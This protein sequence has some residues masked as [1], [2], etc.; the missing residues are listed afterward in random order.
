MEREAKAALQ[1]EL[2]ALELDRSEQIRALSRHKELV[3]QKLAE[4]NS[5]NEAATKALEERLAQEQASRETEKARADDTRTALEGERSNHVATARNLALAQDALAAVQG[6]THAMIGR[7]GQLARGARSNN[8]LQKLLKIPP[9]GKYN[10]RLQRNVDQILGFLA[11]FTD[12]ELGMVSTG[13]EDRV[14]AYMLGMTSF[15]ADMPPLDRNVYLTLHPD[16]AKLKVDPFIHY[17]DFGQREGRS[18]HPLLDYDYYTRRYPET[19]RYE[20]SVLEHYLRFGAA[21][22]YDPCEMFSTSDYLARYP[23]VQHTKYN[24]LLHYLRHPDCQ[25]HPSFDSNFYRK[26]YPDVVRAG[27]NPLV[28]FLLWG[29]AEGRQPTPNRPAD[30][31]HEVQA[32]G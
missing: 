29:R 30:S 2:S 31:G 13:R 19:A 32:G 8:W 21:E 23:D 12:A 16:V 26:Q 11:Q 18:P 15:V 9:I 1:G 20:Y 17:L 22:G 28:H 6:Q 7:I 14:L 3:E 10:R 25:P 27:V 24:P 5:E 4:T